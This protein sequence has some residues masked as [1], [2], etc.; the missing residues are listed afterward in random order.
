MATHESPRILVLV[1]GAARTSR[2]REVAR[3]VCRQIG[4]AGSDPVL[5]DLVDYPLPP[6]GEGNDANVADLLA[7]ASEA[8]GLVWVTPCYH[9]SYS[10]ILK[11]CLDNLR[12]E[13]LRGKPVG[14]IAVGNSLAA[15]QA[16]D[17]LRAVARALGCVAVPTNVVVMGA[18]RAPAAD[19]FTPQGRDTRLRITRMIG[20]LHTLS[21][22]SGQLRNAGDPLLASCMARLNGSL[23]AGSAE[24][25]QAAP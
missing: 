10:G 21:Q 13:E 3:L 12:K 18:G 4:V 5:R 24:G 7:Q 6:L 16:C 23:A 8:D 2:T 14:V 1:G 15:V 17:H 22:V 20:E 25:G 9:G 19:M 11:N